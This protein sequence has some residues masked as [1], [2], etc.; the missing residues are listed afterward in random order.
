[1]T[2]ATDINET[3][4][5]YSKAIAVLRMNE[6][7][8]LEKPFLFIID[9]EM[10]R[11]IVKELPLTGKDIVFDIN[12]FTNADSLAHN[13]E[14]KDII[15]S[16]T[17]VSFQIYEKAFNEVM[18]NLKQGNSY[19]VNLTQP[20]EI[21]INLTS[22]E[23]FDACEAKY[24]LNFMDRF[25]VFSPE[26]FVIIRDQK[27]Y[28]YPMKG[29]IDA[30]IANAKEIILQD[31][32][33]KAEHTTIVDLIRNDMSHFAKNVHVK[34]LRYID[35]VNTNQKNLLQ[36]SSEIVGDLNTNYRN[37]IGDIIFSMLPA[38]SVSGAPKEK[39]IE[40]IKKAE[41]YSRGYY[42]GVFGYFD[43]KDLDSGVM[44]R[45]MERDGDKWIYKSG[46]GITSMSNAQS[47][48]EELIN[49]IYVPVNRKH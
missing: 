2:P 37:C 20:S 46:G 31:A 25:M 14:D 8:S 12:G 38:G 11:P 13:G 21:K 44:I 22:R 30:A 19:L 35:C 48:Y 36:V 18:Q 33:E 47:E 43:G 4:G 40:I 15:F 27:I 34:R 5:L 7:G 16:K 49:K 28:S 26:S 24:K 1:M 17:P 3:D 9:F 45:F 32:K 23:I 42:T 10:L 39:T 41:N 29:T 6:L